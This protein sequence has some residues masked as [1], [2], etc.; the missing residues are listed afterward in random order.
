MLGKW[1]R[2]VLILLVL[3]A[4]LLFVGMAKYGWE[5]MGIKIQTSGEAKK[6]ETKV[7]KE[8]KK[9][10]EKVGEIGEDVL[11]VIKE[12]GGKLGETVKEKVDEAGDKIGKKIEEIKKEIKSSSEEGEATEEDEE[13]L[14]KI[15]EDKSKGSSK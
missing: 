4:I 15:I 6:A 2:R 3:V 8:I 11:D 7:E 13:K 10:A 9:G 14:D 1:I 12:E 5:I